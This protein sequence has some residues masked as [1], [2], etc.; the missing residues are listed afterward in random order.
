MER[1]SRSLSPQER[2]GDINSQETET[3]NWHDVSATAPSPVQ[4]ILFPS[5]GSIDPN[6]RLASP[7]NVPRIITTAKSTSTAQSSSEQTHWQELPGELSRECVRFIRPPNQCAMRFS[8]S[9]LIP[10]SHSSTSTQTVSLHPRIVG[11]RPWIRPDLPISQSYRYADTQALQLQTERSLGASHLNQHEIPIRNR[12]VTQVRLTSRTLE[13]SSSLRTNWQCPSCDPSRIGLRFIRP[14]NSFHGATISKVGMEYHGYGCKRPT[15]IPSY[16]TQT[17]QPDQ[18]VSEPCV[19]TDMMLKDKY[20]LRESPVRRRGRPPLSRVSQEDSRTPPIRRRGRPP[21]SR[22]NQEEGRTPSLRGPSRPPLS[23]FSSP[24]QLPFIEEALQQEISRTSSI[25]RRGRPP[26][27]RVSLEEGR[28]SSIRGLITYPQSPKDEAVST[29]EFLRGRE[30]PPRSRSSLPARLTSDEEDLQQE[31]FGKTSIRGYGRTLLSRSL[32]SRQLSK[33][34]FIRKYIFGTTS[35]KRRGRPPCSRPSSVDENVSSA[36][37]H[38]KGKRGRPPLLEQSG[39]QISGR[40]R[41]ES[42]LTSLSSSSSIGQE[43]P[44]GPFITRSGRL[45][46]QPDRLFSDPNLQLPLKRSQSSQ[47]TLEGMPQQRSREGSAN[48]IRN[49]MRQNPNLRKNKE[50]DT[51][52]E[53]GRDNCN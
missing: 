45:S 32:P 22:V 10:L 52:V 13:R 31:L 33:E 23:R 8:S 21:L 12:N 19:Y 34:D 38:V 30:I 4:K 50:K 39:Q 51:I 24:V 1:P 11:V 5:G 25:R 7:I 48:S 6:Y 53:R 47:Y 27:S 9:K 28:T 40:R 20:V 43:F 46:K 44:R 2:P 16:L 29:E 15:P 3:S 14:P 18:T 42:S 49:I 36:E 17:F 35:P 37:E 41:R 26:V